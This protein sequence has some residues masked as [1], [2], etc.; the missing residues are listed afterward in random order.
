M[1]YLYDNAS[2]K[3]VKHGLTGNEVYIYDE[4]SRPGF[5]LSPRYDMRPLFDG[6]I[7]HGE[8]CYDRIQRK[9][10]WCTRIY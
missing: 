4:Y 9:E 5:G 2:K 8:V 10:V 3:A 1:F 7:S 6:A